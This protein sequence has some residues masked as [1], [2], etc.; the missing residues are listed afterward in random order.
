MATRA[1]YKQ[2]QKVEFTFAGSS[3]TGI[4]LDVRKDGN[5]VS[6]LIQDDRGTKYPVQQD[7]VTKKL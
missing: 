7:K 1:K 5:K 4:I 2:D 3:F 6:Y